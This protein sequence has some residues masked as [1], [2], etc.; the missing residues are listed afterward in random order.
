VAEEPRGEILRAL[1]RPAR[2]GGDRADALLDATPAERTLASRVLLEQAAEVLADAGVLR[3]QQTVLDL[4]L[5]QVS[6]LAAAL[7]AWGAGGRHPA[8][9]TIRSA[10][11]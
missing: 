1:T 3:P 7:A 2:L 5:R 11:C 6:S 4:S 10:T 8:S 9:S